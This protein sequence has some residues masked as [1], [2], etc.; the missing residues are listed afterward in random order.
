MTMN[1]D[2]QHPTQGPVNMGSIPPGAVDLA[3]P[4]LVALRNFVAQCATHQ[5]AAFVGVALFPD[6]QVAIT[7]QC[8]G[9]MVQALGLYQAGIQITSSKLSAPAPVPEQ[10]P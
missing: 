1:N 7:Q 2:G 6:G 8:P 5:A 10:A 3:N 9:G 4:V